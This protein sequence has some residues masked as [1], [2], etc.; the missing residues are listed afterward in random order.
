MCINDLNP[1]E[2]LILSRSDTT[3]PKPSIVE[4][5]IRDGIEERYGSLYAAC[6][7]Y[8]VTVS[9]CDAENLILHVDN[10]YAY[11][12]L[13]KKLLPVIETIISAIYDIHPAISIVHTR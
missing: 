10:Q 6:L 8:S 4:K 5:V 11:Y 9:S 12:L 13:R 2:Y 7:L 1:D 3:I